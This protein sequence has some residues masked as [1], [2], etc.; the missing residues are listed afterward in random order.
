MPAVDGAARDR[1]LSYPSM[2]LA[3]QLSKR[4]RA[5]LRVGTSITEGTANFL[6]NRG[7]TKSQQMR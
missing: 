7:M 2:C 1:P 4:H 5:C 6:V 3:G